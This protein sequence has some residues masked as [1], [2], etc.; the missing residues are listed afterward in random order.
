[1][2]KRNK[3][4]NNHVKCF[5]KHGEQNMKIQKTTFFTAFR[6]SFIFFCISMFAGCASHKET[7][8]SFDRSF[9]G[10]QYL[11]SAKFAADWREKSSQSSDT[12]SLLWN[13]QAGA[14]FRA[15]F[16]YR[17]SNEYFDAAE[18]LL[19]TYDE[20]S[21]VTDFSKH[22]GDMVAN[23]S[24]SDY[25]G[26]IYDGIMINTYKALNFNALGDWE[27]ARVELNRADD[28]QRRAV[29]FFSQDI[30]LRQSELEAQEKQLD[31]DKLKSL[32]RTMNSP[33]IKD[34]IRKEYTDA[35]QWG[36]Y[37]D[38]VNPF[39][40]Y[41]HG[42]LHFLNG[43]NRSDF[44]KAR[45]SM[46][47]IVGMVDVSNNIYVKKDLQ[48]L[49]KIVLGQVQKRQLPPTVW[50][51][52]ENGLRPELDEVRIDIPLFLGTTMYSGIAMPKLINQDTAYRFLRVQGSGEGVV[53]TLPIS[54]MDRIIRA[55]FNSSMPGVLRQAILGA[56]FKN[57][58]QYTIGEGLSFID[59]DLAMVGSLLGAFYQISQTEAD[60]RTWSALPKEFQLARLEDVR[61]K[62]LCILPPY[63]QKEIME[64]VVPDD[65]FSLLHIKIPGK[66]AKPIC[67]TMGFPSETLYSRS[68]GRMK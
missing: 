6:L 31:D 32:Q 27:N 16:D 51:I 3:S 15:A 33:E 18:R 68:I 34:I 12:G 37:P 61:G 44:E 17:K 7:V 39:A 55:E 11:E 40:T 5:K 36:V 19:K 41:L 58:L 66:N 35:H 48:A 43:Q 56:V 42:L 62:T 9:R 30:A 2:I 20:K 54:N 26:N 52:F 57:S 64:I 45:Q 47:R 10:G 21:G 22:A 29:E 63:G 25:R 23:P 28:R 53:E 59:S 49:E 46:K 24:V 4:Q 13:M 67:Y 8:E 60:L 14:A 50:I 1:M 38:F 65:H